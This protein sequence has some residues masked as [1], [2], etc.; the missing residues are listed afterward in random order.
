MLHVRQIRTRSRLN[1]LQPANPA[2]LLK[3][4]NYLLGRALSLLLADT[5]T[6][7]STSNC[8][9]PAQ[10]NVH[11]DAKPTDPE[12]RLRTGGVGLYLGSKTTLFA[13]SARFSR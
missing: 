2:I 12:N 10:T 9:S 5:T 6:G 3:A 13:G 11:S 8:N 4:L 7:R 1:R